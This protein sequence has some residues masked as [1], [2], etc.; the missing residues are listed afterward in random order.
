MRQS[1]QFPLNTILHLRCR[2]LLQNKLSTNYTLQN[3]FQLDE[4]IPLP[5]LALETDLPVSA[6]AKVSEA[7][8][9]HGH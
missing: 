9:G 3:F 1:F 6:F 5:M 2:K 8:F 7:E 4:V